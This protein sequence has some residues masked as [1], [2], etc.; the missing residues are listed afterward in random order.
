M[1]RLYCVLPSLLLETS[2]CFFLFKSCKAFSVSSDLQI[3]H[4]C[5]NGLI[6]GLGPIVFDAILTSGQTSVKLQCLNENLMLNN[7]RRTAFLKK[8]S[9]VN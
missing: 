3:Q 5:S 7:F 6:K 2:G 8:I 9:I 1:H 4:H